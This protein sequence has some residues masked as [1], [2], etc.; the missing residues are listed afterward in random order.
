MANTRLATLKFSREIER[1]TENFT[2]REW[3]FEIID[4]WLHHSDQR[5]FI[6]TGE[7][8]VG[9]SSITARLTQVRPENIAAYHFCTADNVGTI[10]PN[11]ILRSLAAHLGESLPKYGE[12]LANTIKPHQV[13][14][15]IH[16]Q[17]GKVDAGAKVV[18]VVINHVVASNPEEEMEI[19]LRAP[20]AAL[21]PPKTPT[22]ILID[23]LDEAMTY[24]GQ[25]TMIH[26]LAKANDLPSWVRFICTTRPAGVVLSYFK[27][28]APY[29]LEAESQANVADVERYVA[30]RLSQATMQKRLQAAPVT[31]LEL[32]ERLILLADGNFLYSKILLNDIE[33]GQQSLDSLEVLPRSMDEIFHRFLRRFTDE[34]WNERYQ[35]LLGKLAVAQEPLSETQLSSFTAISPRQVRQ[36]LA[37]LEQ[38]LDLVPDGSDSKRYRLFHQSLRDYL[39]SQDRSELFWCDA[40]EEHQ[41]IGRYYTETYQGNWSD[42]DLYGLRY[43]PAHLAGARQLADLR[44]LLLQFSWLHAKLQATN[45][46]ALVDDYELLPADRELALVRDALRLSGHVLVGDEAQLAGQM[47]GRLASYDRPVLTTLVQR[48]RAWLERAWLCPLTPSLTPPGGPL[49]RTMKGRVGG[50]AGTVRSLALTPEGRRA[51]TAGN[52]SNDQTVRIWDL[53]SGMCL[54]TLQGQAASGYTPL[55]LDSAGKRAFTAFGDEVRAWDLVSWTQ[56]AT[57]AGAGD[58]ITA[59]AATAGGEYAII[60]TA[61]GLVLVWHVAVESF[62]LAS[63]GEQV[64]AVAISDDGRWAASVSATLVKVWNLIARQERRTLSIPT[65][66]RGSWSDG[67][68]LWLTGD[69]SRVLF[70]DPPKSW[71][72][73]S[74]IVTDLM[75]QPPLGE[76][77]ALVPNGQRALVKPQVS[78]TVLEVWDILRGEKLLEL[79]HRGYVATAALTH[80]GQCAFSAD[81]EHD[82]FV[83]NLSDEV[84]IQTQMTSGAIVQFEGF[85]PD[86]NA[87]LFR[88]SNG[89]QEV[90]S[91][92]S[93][94]LVPIP[95]PHNELIQEMSAKAKSQA[96]TRKEVARKLKLR[97]DAQAQLLLIISVDRRRTVSAFRFG[98]KAGDYEE[99]EKPGA[100][101]QYGE[102][103][104][105]DLGDEQHL[106]TQPVTT[107]LRGH[108]APVLSL[109]MTPDGRTAISAG[110]G[111]IV[112]VWDLEAKS[113]RWALRGHTGLVSAVAITPDA[114]RAASASEDSTLRLW[115]LENG[116]LL[117]AFSGE[118]WMTGCWLTPEGK[119]VIAAERAGIDKLKF[120]VLRLCGA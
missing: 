61:S 85:T 102:I 23:S 29:L 6:L 69:G 2:G 84:L 107:S 73:E 91:L 77:L 63:H 40:H 9:K 119:T 86:G 71:N 21:E 114:R 72:I 18:G 76:F 26:I 81:F 62:D 8:G 82:L 1:L 27:P 31:H 37:V 48:A 97:G 20:L 96:T 83:W 42:C 5:F 7:P 32:T 100:A 112:R 33:A 39:L 68:L 14:V 19:L 3:L 55:A 52:S 78:D 104:L 66:L 34:H 60:G 36:H 110:W 105:W 30:Y 99:P 43:L 88:L 106:F 10:T 117:A 111:R 17:V 54:H 57:L 90:Y 41:K 13:S 47:V 28:F 56:Y 95:G 93:S 101:D 53:D 92:E 89:Q 94:E 74:G 4:D 12:A 80:D 24:Q 98:G 118:G 45:P 51:I 35:P 15:N 120:H 59:L 103:T 46:A 87:A 25:P 16:Q 58:L 113:E 11:T 65:G 108:S 115:D 67:H 44:A 75:E 22:F 79:E 116:Q 64:F 70:G 109:D 38:Y 49:M 50:H